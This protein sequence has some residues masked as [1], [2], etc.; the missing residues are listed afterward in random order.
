MDELGNYTESAWFSS[1]RRSEL[2]KFT[3]ELH[4]IWNFRLNLTAETKHNI[5]PHGDPFRHHN[6]LNIAT[7]PLEVL[8][9]VV[10]NIIEN[11][12]FSGSTEEYQSLG[13]IYVLTALTLVNNNAAESLPWLFQSVMPINPLS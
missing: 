8:K 5:C 6:L 9:K 10:I 3:R 7:I 12:I 2:I 11:F 13:C 4:D 1:L